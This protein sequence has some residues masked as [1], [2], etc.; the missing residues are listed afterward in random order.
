MLEVIRRWLQ[1]YRDVGRKLDNKWSMTNE[2]NFKC[3]GVT[4][5]MNGA[6]D[7]VVNTVPTESAR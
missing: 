6:V 2:I 1:K 7:A 4:A 5:A 3:G